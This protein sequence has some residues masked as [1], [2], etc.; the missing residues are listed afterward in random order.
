MAMTA[1]PGTLRVLR[2]FL[3]GAILRGLSFLFSAT[4]ERDVNTQP[5]RAFI[6]QAGNKPGSEWQM[7]L[8]SSLNITMLWDHAGFC[9]LNPESR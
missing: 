6:D 4:G 7:P 5:M 2:A 1:C 8:F 9:H 3:P